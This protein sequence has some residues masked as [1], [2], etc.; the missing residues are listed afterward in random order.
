MPYYN[1]WDPGALTDDSLA[2]LVLNVGHGDSIVIRFPILDDRVLCAV[3]DCY[4]SDKVLHTLTQL[5]ATELPFVC[6]THPHSDHMRGFQAMIEACDDRL[7]VAQFWD[8]GFRHVT[9]YH[10]NLIRC[11]QQ[12]SNEISFMRITSG[13]EVTIN[14]VRVVA[15]APSIQL[16]N[17][18]DTFGTNIN[19]SSIVLKLEYPAKDM[20]M[21][22][23][24]PEVYSDDELA[25]EEKIEQNT[26]ILTGD[27]QFDSWAHLTQEFP[28]QSRYRTANRGQKIPWHT[29]SRVTHKPLR[30]QV[31]KVPHHMSKNGISY[32]VME[33]IKAKYAIVSCSNTHR[34][35]CPHQLTIDAANEVYGCETYF[36]GNRDEDLRSGS[37]G[38]LFSGDGTE[39]DVYGMGDTVSEMPPL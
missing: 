7:P 8:C 18:Y 25:S 17:K 39:P 36:T 6:A 32:E 26:M 33:A 24:K 12:R 20:A 31:L 35:T 16:R 13:F 22:F 1:Q 3:V 5:G 27:A 38:I 34:H 28:Q 37:I 10:Y 23:N 11:L 30:S 21:Y 15:L 9:T 29:W 4:K 14:G 2:V 19:N